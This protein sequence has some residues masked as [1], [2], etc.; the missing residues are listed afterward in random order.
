MGFRELTMIEVR[1]LLRRRQAGESAR[2]AAR[3]CGADRKTVK[4]YYEAAEQSGADG[5]L[6]DELVAEVARLVQ[7]RPVPPASEAW[8]TLVPVRARIEAWLSA[9][10]P[11]R[12]VRIHELLAREG[13]TVS[14]STLRRYVQREFGFGGPRVT[15]R[16]ADTAPGEEAQ[17]DFGHVGWIVDVTAKRRKLWAL[18]VTLSFSRYTFVWPTLTQTV[19]DVCEG[20]DGAWNFFG[21]VP[22]RLV[23]DNAS[24]MVTVPSAQ[25]PVL[26]R[27]FQEYAQARGILVDPA[28]VRRPQDKGRVENAVAYVR[29]RWCD[30][31]HFLD[32]GDARRS[33]AR[34]CEE[35]AGARVH[36]TTR[37]VPRVVFAAEEKAHLAPPPQA[38]FDVPVW[39]QAKV[40]PDHHVQVARALYSVPTAYIGRQLEVRFDSMTVRLYAGAE[41]VKVHRRVAPGKRSTDPGD[42]PRTKAAYAL[43]SVD[44]L[45]QAAYGKG[46]HVGAFA[47]KLLAGPLPW[48]K[49][50][51][52]Q[53]LMRLCDRHGTERVEAACTRAVAF[54]VYDVPRI[55]RMLKLARWSEADAEAAGKVVQL[56]GRFARAPDHFTTHRPKGGGAR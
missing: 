43:R 38:R 9:E 29:E 41:L 28:R 49:M 55:E 16:L 8:K 27:S 50:R 17:A 12:L 18:I 36:G 42:Y 48:S 30:G 35:V 56:P 14:Y 40:H 19:S 23:I 11:L 44:A 26:Q 20:L 53:A 39:S 7:G 32:V 1:E 22:R 13:V 47:A 6:T 46:E 4:R 21:G 2:R 15:V 24:S 34:W 3:E 25:T 54:D 10:R 45:V 31:E 33:A 37:A 5:E 52:A 51:Q